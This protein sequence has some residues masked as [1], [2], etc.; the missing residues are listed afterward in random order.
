MNKYY[1]LFLLVILAASVQAEQQS[2]GFVRQGTCIQLPQVH[3]NLTFSNIS[4]VELPDRSFTRLNRAMQNQ[5]QGYWNLTFCNTTQ[6][7][8]YIVNGVA[9]P[10]GVLTGFAYDFEVNPDGKEYTTAQSLTYILALLMATF[11][12][13]LFLVGSVYIPYGNE[14]N[15][16]GQVVKV[17][18]KKYAKIICVS[19]SYLTLMWIFYILHNISLGYLHIASAANFFKVFYRFMIAFM[20]PIFVSVIVIGFVVFI[21]DLKTEKMIERGSLPN[22]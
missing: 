8:T 6:I 14:R 12:L 2:L 13:L 21:R 3:G 20:Y 7:G 17:N 9:N 19:F 1:F 4:S 11:F 10:D 18:Y 16:E 15:G 22:A 5:G